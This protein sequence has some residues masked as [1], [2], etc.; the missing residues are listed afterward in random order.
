MEG[1]LLSLCIPT[2][3]VLEWVMPVLDSIYSQC[4]DE[5][6]YQVVVADNGD[7]EEF[8]RRMNEYINRHDNLKY[9]KT[10]SRGFLNQIDCFKNADGKF[11]K[12]I[13]HR[14][15]LNDGALNYFINF[16]RN[17]EKSDSVVYFS[18]GVL[19]SEKKILKL[20]SFDEFVNSLSYWSSWSA[21]IGFWRNKLSKLSEIKEYNELFPHTEV[22]F[23]DKNSDNYIIDDT[24]LLTQLPV[25]KISK[26][27]YNLF[28]AFAV[29]YPSIICDLLRQDYISLNTFLKIK[30]ENYFFLKQQYFEYIVRG[31]DCSYD[32]TDADQFLNVYYSKRLVKFSMPFMYLKCLLSKLLKALVR[33]N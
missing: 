29:E 10:N 19:N 7:N 8:S 5:S 12:F 30:K 28:K 3:G 25:G 9:I 13:N 24:N 2:N 23:I 27:R 18:N 15:V 26:G 20:N 14:F 21:G 6:L 4:E 16:V 31:K 1:L 17:N 33:K 11:I 32:L 22:L